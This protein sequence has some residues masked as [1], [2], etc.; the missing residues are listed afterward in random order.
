METGVIHSGQMV[1][2]EPAPDT[3]YIIGIDP[4]HVGRS[5]EVEPEFCILVAKMGKY[6]LSPVA[7]YY[8]RPEK[9]EDCFKKAVEVAVKYNKFGTLEKKM[10]HVSCIANAGSADHMFQYFAIHGPLHLLIKR[11]KTIKKENVRTGMF[12][13]MVFR[14]PVYEKVTGATGIVYTSKINEDIRPLVI[15]FMD[16]HWPSLKESGCS[17]AECESAVEAIWAGLVFGDLR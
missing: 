17:R 15:S 10:C 5:P 6:L 9:M 13:D 11:T 16:K 2:E 14:K 1:L 3:E 4:V 8:Q 7:I 12:D